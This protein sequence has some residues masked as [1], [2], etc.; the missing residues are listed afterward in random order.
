M[1]PMG[2]PEMSVMNYHYSLRNNPE[3]SSSRLVGLFNS[4]VR[5]E[6]ADRDIGTVFDVIVLN[7]GQ[8]IRLQCGPRY[9]VRI[10]IASLVADLG[11]PYEDRC[12]YDH[13]K[14]TRQPMYSM[15]QRNIEA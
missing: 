11:A 3:N 2:F 4:T 7:T 9:S 12:I 13:C 15:C 14:L 8:Y 5:Q 10:F 1:R 6:S